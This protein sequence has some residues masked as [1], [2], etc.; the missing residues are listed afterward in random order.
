MTRKEFQKKRKQLWDEMKSLEDEYINTNQLYKKGDVIKVSFRWGSETVV[1]YCVIVCVKIGTNI[2]HNILPY[3]PLDGDITY[4]A[5]YADFED[6]K[7][8][9]KIKPEF[10]PLDNLNGSGECVYFTVC[11]YQFRLEEL[12]TIS[13][14]VVGN[15]TNTKNKITEDAHKMQQNKLQD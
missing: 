1:K 12:E 10:C 13:M 4:V 8:D 2:G 7:L 5:K 9:I 6:D 15:V 14:E 3:S 11:G